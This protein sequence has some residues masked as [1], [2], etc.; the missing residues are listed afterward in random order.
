[1]NFEPND[2]R[3]RRVEGGSLVTVIVPSG[4]LAEARH[5]PQ[6]PQRGF[7][8]LLDKERGVLSYARTEQVLDDAYGNKE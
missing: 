7:Y 6:P 8:H 5:L 1:M 4:K 2:I 3:T